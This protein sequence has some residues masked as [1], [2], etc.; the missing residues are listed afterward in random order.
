[1]PSNTVLNSGSAVGA[2]QILI[3]SYSCV[4]LP[5]ISTAIRT[6]VFSF[7]G[8]LNVL[9]YI[10]HTWSLPGWSSG[11]NLQLIL[12]VGRFWW[13]SSPL[14]TL[15]MGLNCGFISTSACGSSTG[16]CSWGCPGV[17]LTLLL[18][19]TP[20]H[21]GSF[22]L[23]SFVWFYIYLSAGQVLLSTLSWCFV[24]TSVSDGVLLMYP[25][26]VMYSMSTYS[27]P[28]CSVLTSFSIQRNCRKGR[29]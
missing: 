9:L 16:V 17:V 19:S 18:P 8:A 20:S 26:R 3:W 14:A 5:P 2:A 22:T 13:E 24:W 29:W 21:P 1:M 11:F 12:L 27:S 25:W 7:E 10:P 15:P 23:L 4:F 28:S 6:S